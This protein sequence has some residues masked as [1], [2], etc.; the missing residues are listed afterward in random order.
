MDQSCFRRTVAPKARVTIWFDHNRGLAST[1]HRAFIE[2]QKLVRATKFTRI[3]LERR[4]HRASKTKSKQASGRL[5]R[6]DTIMLTFK[7]IHLCVSVSISALVL[8]PQVVSGIVPPLKVKAKLQA[9]RGK[10]SGQR[11]DPVSAK[12][13]S[14]RANDYTP[15]CVEL[16][17]S[18]RTKIDEFSFGDF[19]VFYVSIPQGSFLSCH[20]T[21]GNEGDKTLNMYTFSNR[22]CSIGSSNE[23]IECFIGDSTEI[24]EISVD[25]YGPPTTINLVCTN[26][27]C[28]PGTYGTAVELENRGFGL[29][30]W[31]LSLSENSIL[32]YNA[33]HSLTHYPFFHSFPSFSSRVW[34]RI[35]QRWI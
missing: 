15:I 30:L 14:A 29:P 17:E 12:G 10:Q 27:P 18:Y 13:L 1:G 16:R 21:G 5:E 11:M 32:L 4:F 2:Q 6:Y 35:L 24:V 26:E 20:A 34:R 33:R 9:P 22:F 19:R 23:V 28:I 8:W 7:M 31:L 3:I 25:Y